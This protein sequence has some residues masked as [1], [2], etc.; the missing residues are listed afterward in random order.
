MTVGA[1]QA[2]PVR[3]GAPPGADEPFPDRRRGEPARTFGEIW[4]TPGGIRSITGVSHRTIGLRFIGTG[5]A[6]FLIGG[7]LAL[8]IRLQLMTPDGTFLSDA[9]YNQ[10]F[11]M[12]GT[13]MMFLFAI[14]ILEG[15]AIYLLPMMLGA[16]D[17]VFPRMSL[18]GYL[19]YLLGG[20]LLLSSFIVGAA[21]DSGWFI[22][23]PLSSKAFSPGLSTD[24]WLIAITFV[25]ISSVTAAVEIIVS[26]LSARAPGMSLTR[27]P[28]FAWYI[29][30]TT[31]MIAVGFPPLIIGSIMLESE[32]LLGLPFFD[33]TGGGDPLLWQHLFWI[34]GHPEVY[35]IFLPAAGM[36]ATMVPTF[37]GR[38]LV[39]Y[40]L[41]V[42]AIVS[43]AFLSMGLWVHHMFATGLPQISL[44]YFSGASMAVAIPTGIQIFCLIATISTG[45]VRLEVP[46]LFILGFFFIFVAGGVTGVML[47]SAP[48][49]WQAHDTYFVVAHFHYVLVGGMVFPLFAA[50]YYWF[51]HVRGRMTSKVAGVAAFTLMFIGFNVAFLPMHLTGFVGMPRRVSTYPEGLGWDGLNLISSLGAFVLALGVLIFI[52]DAAWSWHFGPRAPRNPWRASTLEWL[53][54]PVAPNYNF[55]AVPTITSRDPLWHQSELADEDEMRNGWIPLRND[56]KRETMGTHPV[57][58]DPVQVIRL[59]R[60]SWWPVAAAVATGIFFTSVLASQYVVAGVGVLLVLAAFTAW[61]WEPADS[62]TEQAAISGMV[63]P[64]DIVS[65]ASPSWLGVAGALLVISSLY[66]SLIFGYLF[67]WTVDPAFLP[68]DSGANETALV[69]AAVAAVLL[70]VVATVADLGLRRHAHHGASASGQAERHGRSDRNKERHA[71]QVPALILLYSVLCLLLAAAAAAGLIA[72]PWEIDPTADAYGATV[73]LVCAFVALLMTVAAVWYLFVVARLTA[74]RLRPQAGMPLMS[75]ATFARVITIYTLFALALIQYG[76]PLLGQSEQPA[77]ASRLE[78]GGSDG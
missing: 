67:L 4:G 15:M 52:I 25:E 51:P 20:L 59:P 19:C 49:N 36:V 26:I 77:P 14:P 35:I 18:Y 72:A 45:R 21:P 50:F 16:R 11:T 12:H 22:Y 41:I 38:P 33:P 63:L 65:R 66:F 68:A 42:A 37:V 8:M 78:T 7:V 62:G 76:P 57:T 64:V 5:F 39:G 47:A 71:E 55:N 70:A 31:F 61:L 54:R 2:D 44:A 48:Y 6:F 32:R 17:L 75:G 24:F 73:W 56:G 9:V 74:K 29:L 43:M 23:T 30:A 60:P 10:I 34:F 58:G 69:A 1:R 27:M 3:S 40:Y 28:I 13:V 53:H 46:M